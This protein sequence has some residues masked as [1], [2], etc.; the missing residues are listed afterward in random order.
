MVVKANFDMASPRYPNV[1]EPHYSD[2]SL[3]ENNL[4][5]IKDSVHYDMSAR[6]GRL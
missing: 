4:S 6:D 2:F 5:C 1:A 3:N